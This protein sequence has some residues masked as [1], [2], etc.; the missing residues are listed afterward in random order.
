MCKSD[1]DLVFEHRN[2]KITLL[3]ATIGANRL[4]HLNV[5]KS[6]MLYVRYETKNSLN[7][8]ECNTKKEHILSMLLPERAQSS[9]FILKWKTYSCYVSPFLSFE[10]HD[11]DT[12]GHDRRQ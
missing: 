6:A 9:L 10:K 2:H 3:C 5:K 12:I 4:L 1:A 11:L 7:F 8:L